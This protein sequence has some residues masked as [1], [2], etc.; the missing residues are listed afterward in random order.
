MRWVIAPDSFK[1]A[2][3]AEAAAAAMAAGVRRADPDAELCV[4]P[5]ADGG[6]GTLAA[7]HAAVGG[8]WRTHR[9]H[10]AGGEPLDAA[11]LALPDGGA[12]IEV[13][14]V[15][16]LGMSE[17]P[18]MARTSFGVGELI[19]RAVA[20]GACRVAVALGGSSTSDGG[21]G[22]L[23]ALGARF[24]DA[25][26]RLLSAAPHDLLRL[27][28]VE[29]AA[30][31]RLPVPLALW[32]DVDNPLLGEHGACAVFGAQKGLTAA[33]RGALDV[34][35]GRLSLLAGG[36][37]QAPGA[38]AAGGIGWALGLLGARR[39]GGASAVASA[40]GLAAAIAGAGHVLTGE[41]ASDAQTLRGKA[42]FCVARYARTAGVPVTLLSGRVEMSAEL[43]A[44]FDGCFSACHGPVSLEDAIGQAAET[45][46]FAAEQ[47]ARLR[48]A[49]ACRT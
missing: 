13:A 11:Y 34:A 9:V 28:R 37:V 17:A 46:E 32:S 3:S 14:R 33:E 41:G 23:A 21:A 15:V 29:L 4:R 47:V 27:A 42:P 36:D 35:L 18:P 43:A 22:V 26:G 20:D 16:G 10:G 39:A 31:A 49:P 38:G 8:H 48:L 1:G 30:L 45:L 12:L 6:E 7:V 19:L 2:L 25:E 24:V 44:A 40:I 5:M